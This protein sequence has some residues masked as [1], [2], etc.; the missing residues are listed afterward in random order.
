MDNV[1]INGNWTVLLDVDPAPLNYLVIDGTLIADDTRDVNITARSIFIRAGNV[2]AGSASTPFMH[3]LTIQISNTKEDHG[4]YIDPLVAGNK[5]IIVTGSLNLFG[6]APTTVTT[7]LTASATKGDTVISVAS[8]TDWVVGDVLALSPSYGKFSEYEQVTITAIHNATSISVTPLQYNHY[9]SSAPISTPQGA[10]DVNT[11]VG[12]LNRNIKI[13]PG[14][15]YGWGVNVLVYGFDD[16]DIRRVGSVKLVGIELVN[17][18]QYDTSAAALQFLNVIGGNYSSLVEGTSFVNCR[19]WC[20]S[21]NNVMNVT[22]D[23]NV[24]YNGRVFGAQAISFTNFQFTN[25][26][27]IGII[28][29]PTMA[30]GSELVACFAT[31]EYVNPATANV[32]IKNNFCLGSQGHGFA[33]PHIK[34]SELETNP[35]A[36][37]TAGSCQIG[38]IFNNIPTPDKC[39]AFSYVNAYANQIGQI[40]GPISTNRLVFNKF[41]MVDNQRGVTLKF[42]NS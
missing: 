5:Y 28:G 35:F 12:H 27:F 39:K 29:R 40:C 14:P 16:G 2:T 10:I 17:G 21:I 32:Q 11:R 7:F 41:V 30:V 3:K 15:D 6:M 33:F 22:F 36:G 23:N 13:V 31:Y 25:N 19:D 1:T 37:N 42:G 34:C 9:G 8:S 24:F 4:W 26:L 18:G 38:F 20:V